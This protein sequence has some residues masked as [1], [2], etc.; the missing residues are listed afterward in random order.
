MNLHP[1]TELTKH[2][3]WRWLALAGL[4]FMFIRS[5]DPL[6]DA[7]KEYDD[8]QRA[9]QGAQEREQRE[10]KQQNALQEQCGGPE[11]TVVEKVHGGWDCF[12]T[13]GRKV[14]TIPGRPA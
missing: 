14:K 10:V 2:K 13:N 6:L 1:V 5:C 9:Y 7:A 8:L 4:A 11:A 12:D 3:A